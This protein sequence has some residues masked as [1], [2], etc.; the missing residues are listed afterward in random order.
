MKPLVLLLALAVASPA[1]AQIGGEEE[2]APLDFR[3]I[4]EDGLK[5]AVEPAFADFT[6]SAEA[7]A[8]AAAAHCAGTSARDAATSAYAATYAAWMGPELYRFG[9]VEESGAVLKV[10][11]WPDPKNAAGRFLTQLRAASPEDQGN[12]EF[13]AKQSAA[14]QGLPA[15]E[16]LYFGE[17]DPCP[18]AQG[19]AG[20]LARIAA[21]L[22][23][24][25][26]DP[27]EGWASLMRHPGAENP[28][29]QTPSESAVA[30]YRALD[31]G[32]EVL[33]DRRLGRPMERARLAEA[34]RSDLSAAN[35]RAQ[36]DAL[37]KLYDAAFARF[38]PPESFAPLAPLWTETQAA[39]KALPD[40][41]D[42]AALAAPEGKAAVKT[43]HDAVKRLRRALGVRLV[44]TLGVGVGFNALDGD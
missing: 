28:V 43:A 37:R 41:L 9:P 5:G 42:E 11:F 33:A 8:T 7:L 23:A 1:A 14:V 31:Q 35:M 3:A 40:P 25:W 26:E 38:D 19:I 18:A 44:P 4:L 12:P 36:F 10:N 21:E 34:W 13:I 32:L 20:N 29:Y 6:A 27:T 2:A 24:A 30:L 17:G 22:E 39:L 16:R 15:L